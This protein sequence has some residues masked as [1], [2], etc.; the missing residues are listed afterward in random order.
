MKKDIQPITNLLFEVGILSQTPRSGFHFLGSG[1]QSVAEH[2]H[3]VIYAGY[4]LGELEGNVD[5]AKILKMCLF[6]DL[7]EARTSDLNYVHQKYN[8]RHEGKAIHDLTSTLPFGKDIL[9][10]L[11]EYEKRKSKEAIIA[12]DADNIEWILSLKE[13]YDIGNTRAKDWIS[14]AIKR[15][16]TSSAKKLAEQI[17]ESNSDDWWFG[18]K[19][20]EWWVNRGKNI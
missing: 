12:K 14:S 20:D 6:H 18:N 17:I 19:E 10:V 8:E 7:A 4:V 16:K 2:V 5:Q 3:R 11:E 13:Q 1:R 15:L 9:E